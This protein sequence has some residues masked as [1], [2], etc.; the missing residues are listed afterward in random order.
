MTDISCLGTDGAVVDLPNA[1]VAVTPLPGEDITCTFSNT[2]LGRIIVEKR[3]DPDNDPQQFTF[4]GAVAGT[5]GD[6]RADRG[7]RPA[8]SFLHVHRERP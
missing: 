4:T 5:I 8:G 7:Y 2:Q 3:T 6:G 1:S